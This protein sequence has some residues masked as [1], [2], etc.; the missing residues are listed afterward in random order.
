VTKC[1]TAAR[2]ARSA[3]RTHRARSHNV[4]MWVAISPDSRKRFAAVLEYG[5]RSSDIW[6]GL[7]AEFHRLRIAQLDRDHAPEQLADAEQL[8]SLAP[9]ESDSADHVPEFGNRLGHTDLIAAPGAP[10][11]AADLSARRHPDAINA[12][13]SRRAVAM[14]A[15][16]CV[17]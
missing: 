13:D 7:K 16:V 3:R 9:G 11:V 1:K 2:A 6:N 4:P 12:R 8:G 14:I 15:G 17:P 5:L 10:H